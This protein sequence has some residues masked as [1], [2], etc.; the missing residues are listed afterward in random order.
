[1]LFTVEFSTQARRSLARLDPPVQ[2]QLL[3]AVELLQIEPRPPRATRL[4]GGDELYRVRIGDYRIIY[5]IQDDVLTILI[6]QV[7]HRE[8]VYRG[9]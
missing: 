3:A 4:K 9:I 7:G 8:H 1:M 6:V 2:R 5:E